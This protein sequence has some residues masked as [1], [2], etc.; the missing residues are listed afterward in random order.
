MLNQ[1]EPSDTSHVHRTFVAE[2]TSSAI[3]KKDR[4]LKPEV[5]TSR[6]HPSYD[7]HKAKS[8][9][10]ENKRGAGTALHQNHSLS[11]GSI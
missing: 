11:A 7:N 6:A 2:Q 1:A 4:V 5:E 8:K 10:M 3:R 9:N